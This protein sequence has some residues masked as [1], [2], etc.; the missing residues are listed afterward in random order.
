MIYCIGNSHARF[1]SG[2]DCKQPNW[3]HRNASEDLLPYFKTY[4][5]GPVIAYNFYEHHYPTVLDIV[6]NEVVDKE[7]DY[8]MLVVGEVDCRWHLPKQIEIQNKEIS[9]VVSECV[10]RF[11]RSYID[12]QKRG[13]KTICWGAH[14]STTSGHNENV[15]EPVYGECVYR[16]LIAQKYNY[17]L[18]EASKQY[19]IEYISIFENLVDQNN[20]TNMSFFSDYCHLNPAKCLDIVV[21]LLRTKG[22][23]D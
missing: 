20:I 15:E 7:K 17:Y 6:T 21:N 11:F 22:I 3:P 4:S 1:F 13:Y 10:N 9:D 8:V 5:I 12:L 19:N 16:N 23:I 18:H 2:S 14:P